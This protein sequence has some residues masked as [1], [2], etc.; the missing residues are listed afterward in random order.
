MRILKESNK[1]ATNK[2][3]STQIERKARRMWRTQ[4]IIGKILEGIMKKKLLEFTQRHPVRV[5]WIIAILL[6]IIIAPFAILIFTKYPDFGKDIQTVTEGKGYNTNILYSLPIALKVTGGVWFT[7]ILLAMP[8]TASMAAIITSFILK[9]KKGIKELFKRF[10]F[11]SPELSAKEGLKIW[12][13]A[14]FLIISLDFILSLAFNITGEVESASFFK[15]N[16]KYSIWEFIFIFVSSIFFDSGGLM[17]ELGWRGFALPNLQK[18]FTPLKSSIILGVLWSIWHIPI[19]MN[20]NPLSEF[21]PFYFIFTIA[22]ILMSIIITYF[23]NRLGG[24]ILIGVAIHGLF[25][26]STGFKNII[27]PDSLEMNSLMQSSLWIVILMSAVLFILYKEG[28]MLGKREI[29]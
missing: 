9:R 16:T 23:Y 25:N 22:C 11:W 8:A 3:V 6:T 19:K 1:I 7:F 24:S 28:T 2:R 27:T 21:I 17:E 20:V 15:I 13:Q 12:F 29:E 26:D 5:Y 10:R 4:N 18:T 14:I